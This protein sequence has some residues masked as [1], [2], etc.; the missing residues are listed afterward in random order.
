M[1]SIIP[2]IHL[3]NFPFFIPAENPSLS[4]IHFLESIARFICSAG[5]WKIDCSNRTLDRLVHN[6]NISKIYHSCQILP[7]YLGIDKTRRK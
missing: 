3:G 4:L 5:F 7:I 2:T 1:I 6:Y